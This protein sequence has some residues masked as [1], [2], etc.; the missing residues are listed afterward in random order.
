M[1]VVQMRERSH[2]RVRDDAEGEE[3]ERENQDRP[4]NGHGR[5]PPTVEDSI[6]YARFSCDIRHDPDRESVKTPNAARLRISRGMGGR[7]RDE[8]GR[9]RV[10]R[11]RIDL[12]QERRGGVDA[13]RHGGQRP[14]HVA[15]VAQR[16]SGARFGCRSI[17]AAQDPG[18]AGVCS[19]ASG[20]CGL[21]EASIPWSAEH[22]G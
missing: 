5:S 1:P 4:D 16:L 22:V 7:R 18:R 8:R 3:Y 9:R 11:A 21:P 12:V 13:L 15:A 10:V 14:P 17:T 20:G 19:F 2:Q 6:V